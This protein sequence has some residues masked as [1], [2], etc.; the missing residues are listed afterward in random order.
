MIV[1]DQGQ[2]VRQATPQTI[3]EQPERKAI[4][5]LTGPINQSL[6]QI[7]NEPACVRATDW[8]MR[9]QLPPGRLSKRLIAAADSQSLS[10]GIR[11]QSVLFVTEDMY[12]S[13]QHALQRAVTIA[14]SG[15]E[16]IES[17]VLID[18]NRASGWLANV[19][20]LP[21]AVVL[22]IKLHSAANSPRDYHLKAIVSLQA[23]HQLKAYPLPWT[24]YL[25]PEHLI[26][27]RP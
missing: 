7:E 9:L 24:V 1:I 4:A 23:W 12:H 6:I 13:P 3:F 15:S 26:V 16:E 19:S 22:S 11:P 27:L 21:Q 10:V 2:T 20:H 18:K 14:F 25:P 8:N 17:G 5:Q